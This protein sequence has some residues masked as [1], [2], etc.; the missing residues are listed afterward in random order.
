[1]KS[2]EKLPL[3]KEIEMCE[4]FEIKSK[5]TN[6][7][8]SLFKYPAKFTPEIPNWFLRNFTKEG[9]IILDCFCGS[10]TSL[11]ESSLLKRKSFGIDFD[12]ICHLITKTKT[13]NL[14]EEEL[15]L[16][17]NLYKEL[18]KPNEHKMIPDLNNLEHWF[19]DKNIEELS[20]II[21]NINDLKEINSNIK[22]FFLTSYASIIR[23]CS[24]SDQVSPKPYVSSKIKKKP[25]NPNNF[26]IKVV[27]NNLKLFSSK[28]L[29]LFYKTE[30]IG[31]DS[32]N[33]SSYQ[34][35]YDHVITSPPY[36]NSFDYVRIL[37]LENLWL[38]NF[39]SNEIIDHKKKQIG[40][41]FIPSFKY[42]E[43]PAKFGILELDEIINQIYLIDQKRAHVVLNYFN[44][45]NETFRRIEESISKD[46]FFCLVIGD[47]EIRKI[48]IEIYRY[49]IIM[50][51]KM[52]FKLIK[53]FSYLI[54]NPYLR[55]PRSGKGG[56]TLYDHIIIVK[57][58]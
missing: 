28:E 22:N 33:K 1:M 49:F 15:I 56:K 52:G 2:V 54:K 35:K 47:C 42:K 38:R 12:P 30:M 48:K 18:I 43:F 44:D 37:R 58:L 26:F 45:M 24:N 53:N 25:E 11:V 3:N 46:G 55:I 39:T 4:T 36:I 5:K 57:K 40:H 50:L 31:S 14:S 8:H 21:S 17:K 29:S 9:D 6:P 23:K 41:E 51:E 32:R 27:E 20:N 34:K 10:G 19:N 16:I 7:I 13:T